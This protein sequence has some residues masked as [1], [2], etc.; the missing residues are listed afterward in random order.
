VAGLHDGALRIRLS[1]PPIDG[2]A[3]DALLAWLADELELP[4]RGLELLSGHK[5]RRKQVVLHAPFD[6]VQAW[7]RARL[8]SCRD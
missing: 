7:I 8:A 6:V 5:G 1:A 3:N 2:R 4:K